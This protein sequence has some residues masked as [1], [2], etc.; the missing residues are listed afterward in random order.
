[1]L[2]S[3]DLLHTFNQKLIKLSIPIHIQ[4]T[5]KNHS[6]P[7][8]WMRKRR[9]EQFQRVLNVHRGPL[10]QQIQC[11]PHFRTGFPIDALQELGQRLFVATQ[12]ETEFPY[13]ILLFAGQRRRRRISIDY[14]VQ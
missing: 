6:P 2:A 4:M 1:M 9:T 12:I 3:I 5:E 10:V 7:H 11:L 8:N 14:R 13:E